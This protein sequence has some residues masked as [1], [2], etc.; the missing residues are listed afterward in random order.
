ML[1]GSTDGGST[2][3]LISSNSLALPDGRNTSGSPDP[4]A[5]YVQEVRFANLN[6][7]TTY[8]LTFHNYKGG[9]GSTQMQIGDIE[10]IGTSIQGFYFYSQPIDAKVFNQGSAYFSASATSP[11]ATPTVAWY[12]G[13]NGNYVPLSDV[14][15]ISGSQTSGLTVNPA[16]FADSADYVAIAYDGSQYVTSS[17]AHLYVYST[18]MDISLPGDSVL[19]FGDT[20]GTRYGDNTNAVNVFDD[21]FIEWKNGG[22]GDSA[23]AGF[24]PFG[25]PVGIIITPAVGSTVLAGLRFY[26]GQ[27]APQFDPSGFI[28]EGS[29]NGGTSYTTIASGSLDLPSARNSTALPVDPT[30][31]S[32][33]EV[34]FSNTQGYTS[35]RLT[36]PDVRDKDT[37]SYLEIGDVEFLGVPGVGVAQPTISGTTLSGGNLHM[38]GSGGT[39]NGTFS[40]VTNGDL[41][42]PVGSWTQAMTGSFDASG[43]FSISLPVSE[44]NPQ[45]FYLIKTP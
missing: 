4:I 1:E 44:S 2:Y 10:L 8:R 31:A 12:K 13:T 23:G 3:T 7:Y 9:N 37:A 20:T 40:V 19:G 29:N 22:S 32:V 11:T 30:Y 27:D 42:V 5:A 21:S 41:T 43:N 6:S 15:N 18:N 14:G 45:L 24:P 38:V 34:L 28:L 39:P 26:P 36:F 35:Y 16:T 33:Q 25:G 17:I